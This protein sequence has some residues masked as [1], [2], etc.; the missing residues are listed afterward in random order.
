MI[1]MRKD[2]RGLHDLLSKTK[3]VYVEKENWYENR[4]WK[5][6]PWHSVKK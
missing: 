5:W 2:Q 6:S 4:Y 3:V 1:N